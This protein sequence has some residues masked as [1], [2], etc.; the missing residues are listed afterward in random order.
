MFFY[1]ALGMFGSPG[2]K[3]NSYSSS[4]PK[5]DTTL[6]KIGV[7]LVL[8]PGI[9]I[10]GALI[11]VGAGIYFVGKAIKTVGT[12]AIT[13]AVNIATSPYYLMSWIFSKKEQ[14]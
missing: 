9:T 1:Y 11:A 8:V 10:G 7:A 4:K 12:I 2:L 6:L 14:T 3:L 13:T 5:R